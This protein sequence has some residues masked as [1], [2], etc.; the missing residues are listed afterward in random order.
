MPWLGDNIGFKDPQSL[1]GLSLMQ[2]QWMN[3]QQNSALINSMQPGYINSLTGPVQHHAGTDLSQQLG[4]SAP[5]I[6][7]PNNIQFNATRLPQQ[8]PQQQQLD[9][10]P[11]IPST[12]NPLSSIM[13]PQQQLGE[14]VQNL[15]HSSQTL[16]NQ[17]A[18]ILQSQTLVQPSTAILQQ[19][20]PIQNQQLRNPPQNL[21]QQVQQPSILGQ[22]QQP[23]LSVSSQLPDQLNLQLQQ[24]SD[25][26]IQIQLLQKLK[27]QQ[28]HSI[29]VQQSAVQ[30]QMTQLNQLPDQRQL[31]DESQRPMIEQLPPMTASNLL[32][33]SNLMPQQQMTKNSASG[34]MNINTRFSNPSQ[35]PKLQ[36]EQTSL[37]PEA[38]MNMGLPPMSTE[39]H[40]LAPGASLFGAG[41]GPSVITDD[42]PSCSTSPSAGNGPSPVVQPIM[43]SSRTQRSTNIS[44]DMAQSNSTFLSPNTLVPMMKD[45]KTKSEVRTSLN[46]SKS[47]NN[48][49]FNPHGFLCGGTA[50]TNYLDTS[51]S[52]T[53]A[54]LS[55]ND[56]QLQQNT[57]TMPSYYQQGMMFQEISHNGEVQGDMRG[58]ISV[59]Y[60]SNIDGHLGI[61]VSSDLLLGKGIVGLGKDI[62]NNLPSAGILPDYNN[63]KDSQ[64]LTSSMVSQPF[65]VPDVAF[66]SIDSTI[67]D[68]TFLNKGAWAPA[69]QFQRMRTYTKV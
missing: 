10:L 40:I 15:Q 29:L 26:Q 8:A 42:A 32:S 69:P 44:E 65:G 30:Q 3:M 36:H 20:P 1:P 38:Q 27:E 66:D 37:L 2:M 31:L 62:E 39:N 63:S 7:P 49:F 21:Q 25:N 57:N 5:Q 61:P 51:S 4:F 46:F 64:Q 56:V 48:G 12:M 35:Q 19:P 24:M 33:Q 17:G 34:Q 67:N 9:Q 54:C 50:Q 18:P 45:S 53:S 14:T 23:K 6:A 13:Q 16:I 28:Q 60:S 47:Q 43:S 58:S 52:A 22:S 55:Q 41:P 68:S 11:K 59:P